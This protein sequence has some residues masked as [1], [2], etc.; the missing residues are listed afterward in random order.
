MGVLRGKLPYYHHSH[1]D[2]SRCGFLADHTYFEQK[3]KTASGQYLRA[4]S[5]ALIG[6]NEASANLKSPAKL[7]CAVKPDDGLVRR[8]HRLLDYRSY[9]YYRSHPHPNP[10]HRGTSLKLPPSLGLRLPLSGF[11]A[12]PSSETPD[13]FLYARVSSF[14]DES[15]GLSTR[16]LEP[17]GGR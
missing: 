17:R 7:L 11:P 9:P 14:C 12:P 8:S 3:K 10:T 16:F 6:S 13:W 4:L 15:K 5:V 1:W 2:L